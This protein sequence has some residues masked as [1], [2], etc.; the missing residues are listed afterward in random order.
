MI[1]LSGL[2]GRLIFAG[3]IASDGPDAVSPVPAKKDRQNSLS[4]KR[5]FLSLF[6]FIIV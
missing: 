6:V 2:G 4:Q 3:S 1:G 5:S